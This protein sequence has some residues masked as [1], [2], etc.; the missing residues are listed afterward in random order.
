MAVVACPHDPC[1]AGGRA[2]ARCC[3]RRAATAA[4]FPRFLARYGYDIQAFSFPTPL[5][6]GLASLPDVSAIYYEV[7]Y[8]NGNMIA[9]KQIVPEDDAYIS[10]LPSQAMRSTKLVSGRMPAAPDEVLAGFTMQQQ[11]GLH[12]GSIVTVPLYSL[13]QAS[14]LEGGNPPPGGHGSAF[15]S[16][17]SRR[18]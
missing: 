6:K 2:G 3:R 4:A 12:I 15:G 13:A 7:S 10:G 1:G 17:A 18:T 9:N 14:A 11:F 8:A 5:P 16:S